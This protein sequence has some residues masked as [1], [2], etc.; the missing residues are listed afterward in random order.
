MPAQPPAVEQVATQTI[1]CLLYRDQLQDQWQTVLQAPVKYIIGMADFLQVC[2]VTECSCTKWHPNHQQSDT[3]ILDVWQRDF[4]SVHFQKI[5]PVDAQIYTVAMRVTADTY[6]ELF[7]FSGTGGL[8]IEPRTDDGRSQDPRYQ[9]IWVPRQPIT[10]VKA[11][12][13]VQTNPVSLI[14]VGFRYGLKVHNEVAESVHAQINPNEPYIAGSSRTPYRVGP[15][16]WGTT[17]KAIQQLFHQWNWQARPIHTI[18]NA[19]DSSGLMWLVHAACPPASL[20]FQLQHGDVVIHQESPASKEPWRPPQAQASSG[21]FKDK[22]EADFD[23][24]AEAARSLPRNEGVS[25]AQLATLEANLEQKLSKKFHNA[26]ENDVAMAAPLEPRVAQ[27]EQQLAALQTRSGVIESKVDYVHQQVEQ[28]STKFEAA[29]DSKLSDQMQRIEAL[30]TKRA[31]SHEWRGGRWAY[32]RKP[33]APL[34]RLLVMA[35]TMTAADASSYAAPMTVSHADTPSFESMYPA[36]GSSLSGET[37]LTR[38]EA[39]LGQVGVPTMYNT[40]VCPSMH[41]EM[42]ASFCRVW[43]HLISL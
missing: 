15:F 9:T 16:P 34:L 30:I 41:P 24:W 29:L 5:R 31:R 21:E 38:D 22:K 11:L 8:Y 35:I 13:A 25:Q 6:S 14:R 32:L 28:Q 27:L 36:S 37:V 2:K 1:K 18:A 26:E 12:Q 23:P 10:E 33:M 39:L 4:L 43:L 40:V 3:P 7:K 19:K 20:V 17:K 42:I